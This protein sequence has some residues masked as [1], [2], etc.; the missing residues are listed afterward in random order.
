MLKKIVFSAAV[1]GA[2]AVIYTSLPDIRRYW[3]I[4]NM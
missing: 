4:R 1:I 2:A 3:R